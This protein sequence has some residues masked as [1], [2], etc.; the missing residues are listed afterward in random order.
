[1][2]LKIL[3]LASDTKHQKRMLD[4]THN[5]KAKNPLCGDEIQLFFK[6]KKGKI[7]EVSYQGKNCVYCQ[8]SANLISINSNGKKVE[9]MIEVCDCANEFFKNKGDLSEH[10][11][12]YKELL[13]SKNI[14]RKECILLPF[15]ALKKSL[16]NGN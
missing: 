7:S 6:V 12:K 10:L 11:K 14:N 5:S 13:N 3:R 2:D 16:I 15:N 9:E 4:F 1:M 8:A